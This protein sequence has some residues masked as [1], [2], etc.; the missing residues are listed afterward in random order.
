MLVVSNQQRT[1]LRE[2]CQC[3]FHDPAPRRVSLSLA[4]IEFFL[5]D[6]TDVRR[7]M[8]VHSCLIARGII[9]ALIQTKMLRRLGRWRWPLDDNGLESLRE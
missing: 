7:V 5:A 1:T 8:I 4:L 6:L 2:P 9:I 3:S